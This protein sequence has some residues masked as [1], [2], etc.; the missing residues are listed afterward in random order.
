[1]SVRV[2]RTH[3]T[4]IASICDGQGRVLAE[5]VAKRRKT[6]EPCRAVG[7]TL[8]YAR[9][10][11]DLSRHYFELASLADQINSGALGDR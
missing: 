7:D 5:G 10:L 11:A 1:M 3:K 2:T 9:A 6:D 4:T 8:A